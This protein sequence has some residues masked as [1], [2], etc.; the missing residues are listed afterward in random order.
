[1]SRRRRVRSGGGTVATV[2]SV[3]EGR[4]GVGSAQGLQHERRDQDYRE[5]VCS[6]IV[7][8][9][10]LLTEDAFLPRRSMRRPASPALQSCVPVQGS[11]SIADRPHSCAVV[12][13][14]LPREVSR[15]AISNRDSSG[16]SLPKGYRPWGVKWGQLAHPYTDDRGRQRDRLRT[17]DRRL[18]VRTLP[19]RRK[20]KD[21]MKRADGHLWPKGTFLQLAPGSAEKV[22]P[23][24]QR[25]QQ[26][27]DHKEWKG[28]SQPL[29]MTADVASTNH[30]IELKLCA[31]EVVENL[32]TDEGG[33]GG[34]LSGSYALHVAIC[35][36]VAPDDLC[37]QLTGKVEGEV[38]LPKISLRSG[39]KIAKDYMAG[40]MV[41][42]VDSDD[43]DDDADA[44]RGKST[45]DEKS[46]TF[47][48]VCPISKT[49]MRTPVRGRDC[50][51]LQ[52][53]DLRN[54]LHS[55]KNHVGGRWRCGVSERHDTFV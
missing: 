52:C 55:N 22:L 2:G 26:A 45:D 35:E 51:H 8:I 4:G 41:S 49:A 28:V 53:F 36:Y 48:L 47:S 29:D 38:T 15:S 23:I 25:R 6:A 7:S 32:A 10:S 50:K 27:H 13:I 18:V 33:G 3:L 5:C 40:Q 12:Q 21:A 16:K 1:M 54:F 30:P 17:G 44:D 43:S 20:A 39:R 24:V 14:D 46:L 9:A 31:K 34:A 37:D 42:I 11:A 19:L